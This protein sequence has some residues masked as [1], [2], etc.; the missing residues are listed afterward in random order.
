MVDA[1]EL[2][3]DDVFKHHGE[4]KV[5]FGEEGGVSGDVLADVPEDAVSGGLGGAG[6][7]KLGA[8]DPDGGNA[9]VLLALAA[10]VEVEHDAGP[11]AGAAWGRAVG[12]GVRRRVDSVGKGVVEGTVG[13]GG[14]GF[15]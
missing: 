11:R 12:G 14:S 9:I 2:V 4:V 3:V 6:A 8:G 10:G 13:A 15:V 1:S 7:E 5:V